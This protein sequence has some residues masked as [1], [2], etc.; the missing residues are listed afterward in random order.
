[1]KTAHAST[2]PQHH[3]VPRE[4]L[5]DNRDLLMGTDG[6]PR[7]YRL[8]LS[9][10]ETD[11]L[12]PRHRH[13]F[14]QIRF[15][16]EGE[17][18]YADDKVLKAGCVAYFPEG[19]YYGPQTRKQGLYMLVLQ[20]GGASGSGFLGEKQHLQGYEALNQKGKTE[21]GI[22]TYVDEKGT[23]RRTTSSP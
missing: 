8:A 19:V 12:T 4:G 5:L 6:D 17:F 9:R 20:F 1:M 7:N 15:P 22:Y 2:A 10:A 14:D 23:Q 13:N 3:T 18:H 21:K 16:I 11:W